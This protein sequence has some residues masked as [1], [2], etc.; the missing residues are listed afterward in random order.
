MKLTG[1]S[2]AFEI[3]SNKSDNL[4]QRLLNKNNFKRSSSSIAKST[5][6]NSMRMSQA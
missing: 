5:M 4:T 6:P 1:F 3:E 2:H